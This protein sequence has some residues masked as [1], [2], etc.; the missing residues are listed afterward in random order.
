MYHYYER[1]L[2]LGPSTWLVNLPGGS[3]SLR[4]EID[5]SFLVARANMFGR[6]AEQLGDDY[7]AS[8]RVICM[9]QF[10]DLALSDEYELRQA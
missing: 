7:D 10:L 9:A 5:H 3:K 1:H 6:F 2:P 4:M 8:N